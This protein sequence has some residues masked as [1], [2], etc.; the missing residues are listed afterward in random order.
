M[1]RLRRDVEVRS[2]ISVEAAASSS[3]AICYKTLQ[4]GS[5]E[6]LEPQRVPP[7]HLQ[8]IAVTDGGAITPLDAARGVHCEWTDSSSG[9]L[10]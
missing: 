8:V 5:R 2:L 6:K 7:A 3:H 1:V 4:Q 9:Q 10:W